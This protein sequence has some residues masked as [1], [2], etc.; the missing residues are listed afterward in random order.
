MLTR[1]SE[2]SPLAFTTSPCDVPV[3]HRG[4]TRESVV[5]SHIYAKKRVDTPVSII[6]LDYT[7][8]SVNVCVS[9]LALW[10]CNPRGILSSLLLNASLEA[11]DRLG[12]PLL[13]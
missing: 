3:H 4:V 7:R 10:A 8:E 1:N 6:C 5:F 9:A 11:F 13:L 2:R 12:E